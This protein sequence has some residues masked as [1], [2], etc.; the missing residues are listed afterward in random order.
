METAL[1]PR[2]FPDWRAGQFDRAED[3]AYLF[4]Y[5]L[6]LHCREEA[7]A[8]LPADASPEV[9]LQLKRRWTPHYITC[10]TCLKGSG[11]LMQALTTLFRWRSRSKFVMRRTALSKHKQSRPANSTCQ[12]V[13]GSGR[14]RVSSDKRAREA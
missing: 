1:P 9:K 7:M 14:K 12:L 5:Y 6:M 13:T 8:T 3:A 10:A 11:D 2:E 4:G